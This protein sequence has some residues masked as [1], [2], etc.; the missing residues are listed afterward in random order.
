MERH[1][2]RYPVT[3]SERGEI[4]GEVVRRVVDE[5][6]RAAEKSPEAAIEYVINDTLYFEKQRARNEGKTKEMQEEMKFLQST[7]RR[8]T[9]AT[10][11]KKKKMLESIVGRCAEEIAGH[12]D[13]RVFAFSTR[14]LPLGLEAIFNAFSPTFFIRNFPNAPDLTSRIAIRGDIDHIRKVAERGTLIVV[15]SHSSNLDSVVVGWALHEAGLPPVN[16]GAGKNLF[17]NPLLS[18]FMNSLGAYKVDRKKKHALYKE[19]LKIYSLVLLECGYHSLFFPGGARSRSGMVERKLKLGLLGT[20]ITAYINNL[21]N[22]KEPAEIY[23]VP[24]TINYPIV[25]EAETL[26][27]DYLKEVGKSRYIIE[28][29]DSYKPF[30]AISFM[31]KLMGLESSMALQFAPPLDP[32]GNRVDEEGKSLGPRGRVIDI[33][34]YVTNAAGEITHDAARDA[35]YT[36][37]LG[38]SIADAFRRNIVA[39]STHALAFV[40]FE[41][42]RAANPG[43]D[44]YRLLRFEGRGARLVTK[45]VLSSLEKLVSRLLELERAGKIQIGGAIRPGDCCREIM[46]EALRFFGMFHSRPAVV[47][48]GDQLKLNDLNLLLYYHNRLVGWGLESLFNGGGKNG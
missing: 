38:A 5:R 16:Y 10:E 25:L 40:L 45:D 14:V 42:L 20:G 8:L 44:L 4:I 43:V 34:R 27:D 9:S 6:V 23:I 41:M 21:V 30:K 7:T 33:R 28:D 46:S 19:T 48:K 11:E 35:E 22:K 12:F 15:P 1:K 37:E 24:M 47:R 13:P 18:F 29:D 31:T 17:T 3:E 36:R 26:I 32:F 2:W 39:L